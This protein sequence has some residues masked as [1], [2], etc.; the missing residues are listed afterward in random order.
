MAFADRLLLDLAFT[1]F[2]I[3]S[4]LA[5]AFYARPSVCDCGYCVFGGEQIFVLGSWQMNLIMRLWGKALTPMSLRWQ[6]IAFTLLVSVYLVELARGHLARMPFIGQQA[7]AAMAG[8]Y[9]GI[10]SYRLR[11]KV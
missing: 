3:S 2:L 9:E 6:M 4:I 10:P 5:S 7:E 11:R 8:G 1:A